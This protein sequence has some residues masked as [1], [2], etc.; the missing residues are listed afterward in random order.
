MKRF[1]PVECFRKKGNTFRGI[2]FFSLLPEFPEISVPFV[3][4]HQ[5][6]ALS[7]SYFRERM[8]KILNMAADF[9]NVY[10]CNVCLFSSVVLADVLV[11]RCVTFVTLLSPAGI[12]PVAV[13]FLTTISLVALCILEKMSLNFIQRIRCYRLLKISKDSI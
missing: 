11:S 6:Q 5:C 10:R 2:P 12:F 13:T 4:T 8:L 9:Q 7:R 3:H 1:I